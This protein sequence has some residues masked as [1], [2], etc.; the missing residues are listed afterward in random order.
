M[1]ITAEYDV[2]RDDGSRYAKH[3]AND[4]VRVIYRDYPGMIHGFFNYGKFIDEGMTARKD[5]A[6]GIKELLGS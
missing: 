5:I 1:V 6:D 4:G 3:L 2:L